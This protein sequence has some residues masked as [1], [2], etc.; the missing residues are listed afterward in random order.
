L[1]HNPSL[2][3]RP[4]RTGRAV[5]RLAGVKPVCVLASIVFIFDCLIICS[6]LCFFVL[7]RPQGLFLVFN[8]RADLPT[9]GACLKTAPEFPAFCVQVSIA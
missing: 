3:A 6:C 5:V 4:W 9:L 7:F 8:W 2:K 1:G